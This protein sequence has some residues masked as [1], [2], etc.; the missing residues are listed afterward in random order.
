LGLEEGI[1][2]NFQYL[3]GNL[4]DNTLFFFENIR[5]P[6]VFTF[7]SL[8]GLAYKKIWKTKVFLILWSLTFFSMYLFLC[9][10]SFNFFSNVRY[11]LTLYIPLAIL[12]GY[13]AVLI[14]DILK[15][16]FK[17]S[18]IS[19]AII[20]LVICLSF[21]PFIGFVSS[22]DDVYNTEREI[23]NFLVNNLDKI[24]KESIVISFEPYIVLINNNHA[25]SAEHSTDFELMNNI[26]KEY[27]HVYFFE[28]YYNSDSPQK[29]YYEFIHGNFKLVSY[30][31]S[32]YGSTV[33]TF[34]KLE[35]WK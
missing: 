14:S 10:G 6:V 17:K 25:L 13:G 32:F 33:F 23:H 19:T 3:E 8:I 35:G 1:I 21:I 4:Q 9:S 5:F 12:G 26:F 16:I 30:N 11:S 2:F 15:K 31:S 27:N 28:H 20:T 18:A 7:L 24:E 22:Y 29:D 34:Y